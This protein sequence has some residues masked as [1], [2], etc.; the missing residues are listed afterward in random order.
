M[1]DQLIN[2]M[3][4]RNLWMA[5]KATD[6]CFDGSDYKQLH[7]TKIYSC[8]KICSFKKKWN[9]LQKW[10]GLKNFL[11]A[12]KIVFPIQNWPN[13]IAKTH[14]HCEMGWKCIWLLPRKCHFFSRGVIN[15]RDESAQH[16]EK[17]WLSYFTYKVE[18]V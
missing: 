5:P 8:S 18:R 6:G 10:F 14:L 11:I 3:C 7:L 4:Q 13:E 2:P 15:V 1:S 16:G 17:L 9:M 12:P